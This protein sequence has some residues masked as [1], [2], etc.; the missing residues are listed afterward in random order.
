M[1]WVAK[2]A[3]V[4]TLLSRYPA[5]CG[6]FFVLVRCEIIWGKFCVELEIYVKWNRVA[7]VFFTSS[8]YYHETDYNSA[9]ISDSVSQA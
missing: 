1:L 5:I 7:L 6:I 9:R 3:H 8:L 4:R 2:N